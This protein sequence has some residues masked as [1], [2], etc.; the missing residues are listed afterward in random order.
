MYNNLLRILRITLELGKNQ[1]SKAFRTH[2]YNI[3]TI[4]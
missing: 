3:T 4:L 2:L 1:V